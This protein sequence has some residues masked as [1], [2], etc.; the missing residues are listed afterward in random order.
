MLY[1]CG[2]YFIVYIRTPWTYEDIHS[3]KTHTCKLERKWLTIDEHNF[4]DE[5]NKVI[6]LLRDSRSK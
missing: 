6:A 5:R 1:T 3:D 4:K 2:I